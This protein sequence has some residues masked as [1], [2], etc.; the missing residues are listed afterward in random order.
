MQHIGEDSVR[1]TQKDEKQRIGQT[2]A[3]SPRQVTVKPGITVSRSVSSFSYKEGLYLCSL[4]GSFLHLVSSDRTM[5]S[6]GI[7]RPKWT[8]GPGVP[9]TTPFKAGEDEIDH[10]ALAKQVVRC[11][12]AGIN[13]VLLGTTGEGWFHYFVSRRNLTLQLTTSPTLRE[14][15]PLRRLERLSMMPVYKMHLCSL[16]QVVDLFRLP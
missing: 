9:L 12:K 11:A 13:I 7:H 1:K 3:K 6:N 15:L 4:I 16:E 5:T 2:A 8:N 14:K 10:E